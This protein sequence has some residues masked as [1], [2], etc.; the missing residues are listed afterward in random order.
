MK[1]ITQYNPPIGGYYSTN[2]GTIIIPLLLIKKPPLIENK[3][4]NA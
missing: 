1:N 3:F 2:K 4:Y